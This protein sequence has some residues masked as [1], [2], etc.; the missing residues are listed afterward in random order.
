MNRIISATTMPFKDRETRYQKLMNQ[1][2]RQGVKTKVL[3]LSA[4]P[5]QQPL[6]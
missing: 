4:T 3:M 5:G 1:V 2:I 6:Q